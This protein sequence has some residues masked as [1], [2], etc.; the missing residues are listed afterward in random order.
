MGICASVVKLHLTEKLFSYLVI[1]SKRLF[2]CSTCNYLFWSL[3]Y[4]WIVKVTKRTIDP[5]K[6]NAIEPVNNVNFHASWIYHETCACACWNFLYS[7][8]Y[9]NVLKG[10]RSYWIKQKIAVNT[11]CFNNIFS[12][13][14]INIA[15]TWRNNLAEGFVRWMFDKK[16]SYLSDAFCA[17]FC[18][19]FIYQST[20][21]QKPIFHKMLTFLEY[22]P[23]KFY[24]FTQILK[25]DAKIEERK[26]K[27]A[28]LVAQFEWVQWLETSGQF[29]LSYTRFAD[30]IST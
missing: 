23:N 5:E 6:L 27:I 24:G 15:A 7:A 12:S 4:S 10:L 13:L 26:T 8:M 14:Y 16:I 21:Q 1:L 17:I 20:C 22:T 28:E 30:V 29:F 19:I 2:Y 3:H 18:A 9:A 25:C 11:F